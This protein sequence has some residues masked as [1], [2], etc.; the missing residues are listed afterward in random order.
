MKNFLCP[1][2]RLS[3]TASANSA[4]KTAASDTLTEAGYA[5]CGNENQPTV[6]SWILL[7]DLPHLLDGTVCHAVRRVNG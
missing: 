2:H 3:P 5:R 6:L 7:P 1:L 4:A